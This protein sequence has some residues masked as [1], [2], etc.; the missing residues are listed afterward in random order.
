[1]SNLL[2]SKLSAVRRRHVTVSLGMGLALLLII[3]PLFLVGGMLIDW[4]IEL[5]F[6]ART[7]ILAVH[8]AAIIWIVVRRM[9]APVAFAPDDESCA[10]WCESE[11]PDTR[12]RL[13][14]AVQLARTDTA[15]AGASGPMIARLVAETEAYVEP[16]DLSSVVK[17]EPFARL[18]AVAALLLISGMLA[19]AWGGQ[20]SVDLLK[21]AMLVPGVDV[22]RKTRVELLVDNPLVIAR[23]DAAVIRA[24]AR[25]IVPSDGTLRIT[26]DNGAERSFAMSPTSEDRTDQ[27]EVTIENVQDSFNYRVYLNDGRSA[28][29][30]VEAAVRPAA[31]SLEI[32]QHFPAYTG[33]EPQRRAPGDLTILEGSRLSVQVRANKPTRPTGVGQAD[34]NRVRLLGSSV[35]VPLTTDMDDRTILRAGQSTPAGFAVPAGTTGLSVL[36]VDDLGLLSRD[37]AVYR[38]QLVPDQPPAVTVNAPTQKESLVTR[39]ATMPVA[40]DVSDDFG[41]ASLKLRYEMKTEARTVGGDGL[42]AEYF[43][44]DSLRGSPKLRRVESQIDFDWGSGS[45]AQGVREDKFTARFTGLI[46]A[47]HDGEWIISADVDDSIRLWIEDR[48]VLDAWGEARQVESDPINLQAGQALP[49]RIEYRENAGTA[50]LKLSWQHARQPRQIIPRQALFSSQQA[51]ERA[52]NLGS[53]SID[54]QIAPGQRQVRGFY[55]W[56]LD[57]IRP[58]PTEGTV[59]QFWLEAADNNNVSGPGITQSDRYAIRIGTE[60]EVRANLMNRLGDYESQMEDLRQNQQDLS[61]RFGQRILGS[62]GSSNTPAINE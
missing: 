50:K 24:A 23:G 29:A 39:F 25:G 40:F 37:A 43:D 28:E 7:A 16:L 9:I 19:F 12:S 3:T 36:L 11:F 26:Y 42:S 62:P 21:R 34:M 14:S 45:P 27:F 18:A 32:V 8:L 55:E 4:W 44:N 56:R 46:V 61:D 48:L 47:P 20:S 52:G 2:H 5:P 58:V 1:M 41:I 51:F 6:V 13:I 22:P 15:P 10:L 17:I 49:V 31:Q 54:L 59:I 38:V 33:L 53:G 60:A 30:R 35:D 57:A